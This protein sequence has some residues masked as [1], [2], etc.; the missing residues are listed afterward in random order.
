MISSARVT[1]SRLIVSFAVLALVQALNV[2]LAAGQGFRP[3]RPVEGVYKDRIT[4]HWLAGN[5]RFWYRND[6]AGKARE[7]ILVDAERG[8]REPAFDHARLAAALS[9]A[10]GAEYKADQLPFD[11]IEYVAQP[12]SAGDDPPRGRGS[13]TAEEH[14]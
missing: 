8:T 2:S 11:M 13:Y 5:T 6:L 12:P 14:A 3:S 4:P 10:A 7:F 9:K 1:T